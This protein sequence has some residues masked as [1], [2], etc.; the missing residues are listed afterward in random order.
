MD[1]RQLEYFL[2]VVDHG[3]MSRA[4]HALYIAQPSLSQAVRVLERDLGTRLFDRVGRRLVLTQ[5]GHALVEPARQIVRGLDAA[6]AA[7]DSVGGLE[8]GRVEIAAMPSQAV[9]PLSGMIRRFTARHPGLTVAV[10]SAFTPDDVL[11]MVRGG[12]TE[13]GLAA[14]PEPLEAAGLTVIPCGRQRF[15]LVTGPDAPFPDGEPV[16]RELLDG[17]RLIV[18]QPGTG[19][20]RL[21]DD[22]RASGVGVVPVVETEHREA[23]L[24]LVLGGVGM[25]V[26]A[27]SWTSL[28]ERAGARVFALDPPAHLHVALVGRA[29]LTPTA[30]AFV[31][32][33]DRP[34][35]SDG[36]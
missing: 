16:R 33:I 32:A 9:E 11:G 18:G 2:A 34:G 5:A 13:L 1:A 30:A 4:A 25:A 3:G 28:A 15:V 7:V 21:V 14:G 35:L 27:D 19:M 22:I 23:I 36:P 24:P 12:V 31:A 17:R 8:A 6:R 29:A 10:R 26:L 20:R